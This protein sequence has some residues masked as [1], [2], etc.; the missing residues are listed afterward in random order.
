MRRSL[1]RKRE[2]DRLP[3]TGSAAGRRRVAGVQGHPKHQVT[4]SQQATTSLAKLRPQPHSQVMDN[5]IATSSWVVD[6]SG[7][8]REY[9]GVLRWL[10][11]ASVEEGPPHRLN[12]QRLAKVLPIKR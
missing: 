2:H 1:K 11:F 4:R 7:E 12:G 10:R 9:R 3:R 8:T 5:G 6:R